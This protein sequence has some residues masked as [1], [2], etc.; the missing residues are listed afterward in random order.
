MRKLR[1]ALALAGGLAA[2]HATHAEDWRVEARSAKR[3]DGE[4]TQV[5]GDIYVHAPADTPADAAPRMGGGC[6]LADLVEYGIGLASCASSA[7]CNSP[8]AIDKSSDPQLQSFYGYCVWRSANE[9]AGRCW[10]RPGPPDSHCIRSIDGH[11]LTPGAHQ[12][13]P[14]PVRPLS[15]LPAEP[16]WIVFAC[17]AD[18]AHPAA[19]GEPESQSRQIS[20][21]PLRD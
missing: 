17:I 15:T 6:L 1:F 20:T 7:D 11:A 19:C 5:V 4:P 3:V 16:E 18:E 13:G 12:L 9:S 21:S 2:T 10:T 14:V 8:T